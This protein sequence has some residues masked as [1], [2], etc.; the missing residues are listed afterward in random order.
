MFCRYCVWMYTYFGVVGYMECVFNGCSLYMLHGAKW[1]CLLVLKLMSYTKQD[2]D[3]V[4]E[5]YRTFVALIDLLYGNFLFIS[6]A[7]WRGKTDGNSW[8]VRFAN[9]TIKS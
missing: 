4:S 7:N 1:I 9:Q 6:L 8:M 2:F 3:S 5:T